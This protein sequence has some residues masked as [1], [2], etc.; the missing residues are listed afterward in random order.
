MSPKTTVASKK[1]SLNHLNRQLGVY[2]LAAAAAGVSILAVATPAESEVVVTNKTIQIPLA[3]LGHGGVDISFQNNGVNDLKLVLSSFSVFGNNGNSL[4]AVNASE[5]QGVLGQH[6][7]RVNNALALAKGAR[8]GAGRYFVPGPGKGT[9]FSY[10]RSAARLAGT[11]TSSFESGHTVDGPWAGDDKTAYLGVQFLI[12]GETHYGW[13]RLTVSTTTPRRSSATILAYAYET[14]AGKP[15]FAGETEGP[16]AE[17]QA[18]E[19]MRKQPGPALG[20]LAAGA[21]GLPL[22]RREESLTSN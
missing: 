15:I 19:N 20:M 12:D 18:P 5:G 13:V 10:G 7:S 2:S 22:W 16:T 17:V 11:H 21:E 4:K 14:E 6:S 1:L 3:N 9:Y 8:I